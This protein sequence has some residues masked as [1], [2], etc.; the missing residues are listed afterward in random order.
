MEKTL[1][2]S[3]ILRLRA[4]QSGIRYRYSTTSNQRIPQKVRAWP[5]TD[6]ILCDWPLYRASQLGKRFAKLSGRA[7]DD[8]LER[9]IEVGHGLKSGG[10][11][12]FAN[13]RVGIEQKRLRFLHSNSR[14]VVD[15][16]YPGRFLEHLAKVMPAN[17][18]R[19][20][21][22]PERQRL[23]LMLLDELP[24]SRHARGLVLFAPYNQLIR[25]DRKV[26]RKNTQEP[27][28]RAI[29]VRR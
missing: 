21:Y 15:E 5:P 29:S 8:S 2:T 23:G 10:E 7:T 13:S 25:Q 9:A 3:E 20:G 17:I 28:H 19:V 26:L 6:L 1:G 12:S 27:Q 18:S 24:R 22:P 4:P 16:M 14:E 11:G